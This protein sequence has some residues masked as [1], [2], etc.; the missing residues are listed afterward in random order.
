MLKAITIEYLL[1]SEVTAGV[2]HKGEE[3]VTRLFDA[4]C[5]CCHAPK[6]RDRYLLFPRRLRPRLRSLSDNQ[7]AQLRVI[8]DYLAGLTEGQARHLYSRFF[9]PGHG[10]LGA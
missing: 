8:C 6:P 1:K 9:E 10:H 4:L 5:E 7:S 2:F 3:I